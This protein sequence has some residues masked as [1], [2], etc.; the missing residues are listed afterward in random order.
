VPTSLVR[1][2]EMVASQSESWTLSNATN[3]L[4]ELTVYSCMWNRKFL[5][6]LVPVF[7]ISFIS[8]RS[9]ATEASGRAR[10]WLAISRFWCNDTCKLMQCRLYM[11]CD[12][13]FQPNTILRI[14]HFTH[15]GISAFAP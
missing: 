12:E 11:R 4:A 9:S 5:Q 15:E 7:K 3:G 2:R 1:T 6:L 14:L 13:H 10:L 8:L